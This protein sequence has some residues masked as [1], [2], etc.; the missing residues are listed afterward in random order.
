[1]RFQSPTEAGPDPFTP[2][3]DVHGPRRVNVGSGPFGGTGS[4]LVCDRELLISSLRARP[5]R[6]HAW[7]QARGIAPTARTV[8]RYIRNLRPVTL[9]TDTRVTNNSF[10]GGRAVPF[11]AILQSGTAILVDRA[12][13]PVARCRC[14]N[15]LLK[16]VYV[17]QAT[18]IL[19]PPHYTPPPPCSSFE[20]CFRRYIGA[21]AVQATGARKRQ[22][23][24][25]PTQTLPPPTPAGAAFSP[26]V[27][28]PN[29]TYTLTVSGFDAN[30]PLNLVLTRPDG[31]VENY[32]FS[33]NASGEGSYTFGYTGPDVLL[34]TYR[35][36]VSG[37]GESASANTTVRG[38]SGGGTET[39]PTTPTT[40]TPPPATT[41]TETAPPA[42]T[43][44][45]GLQ[46]DPP[47]SQLEAEQC[48]MQQGSPP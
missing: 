41:D 43:G 26:E 2:P 44:T 25:A 27:G 7:A 20:D 47:R 11:Q 42:Q 24:P 22:R 14:G 21:P 6:L 9:T 18:C 36:V 8:G 1:V 12:G 39:T 35:A 4:D 28:G 33:T 31:G 16:P 34:G 30:I 10:V 40:T 5:D 32:S 13:D 46:C 45:D 19:C 23:P 38:E 15:P 3:A 29:D 37:G 17:P 48:A